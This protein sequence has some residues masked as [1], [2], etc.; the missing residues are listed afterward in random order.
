VGSSF[1]GNS[2]VLV[3]EGGMSSLRGAA[4]LPQKRVSPG[5][6]NWH[7]GHFM[8]ICFLA[9]NQKHYQLIRH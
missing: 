4:Q 7:A 5:F 3:K 8:L 9:Y 2:R 1:L 6:S